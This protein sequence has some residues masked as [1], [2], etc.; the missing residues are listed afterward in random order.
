V[1][2]CNGTE[3]TYYANL[4]RANGFKEPFN[5]RYWSLG[6][7]ESAVPDIGRLSDPS[8]YAEEA[9]LYSKMMKLTDQSI[10]L[11][12]NGDLGNMLWTKEVLDQVQPI[13][14]YLSVHKYIRSQ[15]GDNLSLYKSIT[16]FEREIIRLD[17]LLGTYP[18]KITNF[19]R[20]YR[21][22]PRQEKIKI[23]VDEWGIWEL[24]CPGTY[25]LECDYNW[26]HALATGSFLNSLQRHSQS[27]EVA[28]WAQLVNILGTIRAD[29]K[30]SQKSTVFYPFKYFRQYVG[31]K[32]LELKTIN[33][34]YIDNSNV[35]SLDISA[36]ID[37]SLNRVVL[38]VI[39]RDLKS[40]VSLKLDFNGLK[41]SNCEMTRLFS[42]NEN[43]MN[44]LGKE[45]IVKIEKSTPASFGNFTLKSSSIYILAMTY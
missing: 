38:F 23:S 45:D 15:P 32:Y 30:G 28:N 6:N 31:T 43:E 2:Y 37:E 16:S 44:L 39:N 40:D 41:I 42:E 20:W 21:F 3:N 26:R 8:K 27:I 11:F 19:P 25:G 24:N 35:E 10:K 17:S 36:T 4:R 12:F 14:D 33:S 7:E 13:C 29:D 5:V 9:F 18:E 34:C 1:E 22:Q